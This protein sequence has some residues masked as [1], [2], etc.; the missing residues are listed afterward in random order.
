MGS[1]S[2][3]MGAPGSSRCGSALLC[4]HQADT[5]TQRLSAD[6]LDPASARELPPPSRSLRLTPHLFSYLLPFINEYDICPREDSWGE[7]GVQHAKLAYAPYA[8]LFVV[9]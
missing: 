7:G 4:R 1:P 6:T 3:G 8:V 2:T 5:S 9:F